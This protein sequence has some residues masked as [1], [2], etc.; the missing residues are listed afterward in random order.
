MVYEYDDGVIWT[1]IDP[2]AQQQRRPHRPLGQLLRPGGHGPHP[3]RRQG[4]RARRNEALRRARSAASTT[5]RGQR[6]IAD[7]YRNVT[8]GHFE[9]PTARRAV[10]GTLT[11][12]LGRDASARR[13]YMTMDEL[14]REN[15]KLEIDLKGLRA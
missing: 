11:A 1:H 9:N 8:E 14:I 4:L 13:R 3:V 2:V 10:D 12:I 15:R 6:N 5:R 7:F